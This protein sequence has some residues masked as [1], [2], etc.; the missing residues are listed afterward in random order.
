MKIN[1]LSILIPV[2][3][4]EK[5]LKTIVEKVNN[6][7]EFEKLTFYKRE[8]FIMDYNSINLDNDCGSKAILNLTFSK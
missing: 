4:E 8:K 2:F 1:K 6:F 3:N 5:T 7:N